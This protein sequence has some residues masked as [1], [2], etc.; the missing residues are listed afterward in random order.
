M[1]LRNLTCI[2][3][4]SRDDMYGK[5]TRISAFNLKINKSIYPK[6]QSG[7]TRGK[8]LALNEEK[9]KSYFKFAN[10]LSH[11]SNLMTDHPG[12]EPSF[13]LRVEY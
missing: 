8:G 13:V 5:L 6:Y 9:R 4:D 12:R 7:G 10:Y 1:C 2:I 11:L 3:R